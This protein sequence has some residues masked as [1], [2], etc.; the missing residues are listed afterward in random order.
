LRSAKECLAHTSDAQILVPFSHHRP[1]LAEKDLAFFTMA[2]EM[3]FVSVKHED[4]KMPAMFEKDP[5][6]LKVR[7]TIH[8]YSLRRTN[9]SE[10]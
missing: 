10:E 2:E 9:L 1:H 3:G 4:A 7:E 8:F 6:C 5:G